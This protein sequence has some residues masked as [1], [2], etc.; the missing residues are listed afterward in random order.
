MSA[1]CR[2]D[3]DL[4]QDVADLFY[5]RLFSIA[6]HVNAKVIL[7]EVGGLAQARRVACLAHHSLPEH[8]M[9]MDMV[10][11][12]SG[13]NMIGTDQDKGEVMSKRSKGGIEIWRDW[14]DPASTSSSS[15]STEGTNLLPNDVIEAK[16]RNSHAE[17]VE[18][19]VLGQGNG[20]SVLTWR[21]SGG[22]WLGR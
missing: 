4:I 20:R 12:S 15:P 19:K 5:P 18:V 16:E 2:K 3:S 7:V 17:N 11:M 9:H 14:L 8:T 1:Y 13:T 21:G 22:E 10:G 6:N